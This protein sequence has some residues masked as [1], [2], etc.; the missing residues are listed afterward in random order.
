MDWIESHTTVSHHPKTRRLSRSLGVP[1]A[2]VVGHLHCLWHWAAKFAPDGDLTKFDA[3]D[4]AFGAM[5]DRGDYSEGSDVEAEEFL[6]ALIDRRF[7]D[8]DENGRRLH[9]WSTY[10]GTFL[11]G[12]REA[13]RRGAFG[14]HKRWHVDRKVSDPDC[15]FC[16]QLSGASPPDEPSDSQGES[17]GDSPSSHLTVPDL[18]RPDPT[19]Q[20]DLPDITNTGDGD[21][22][23][24]ILEE[25]MRGHFWNTFL[26]DDIDAAV[27][28]LTLRNRYGERIKDPVAWLTKVL[29]S[30]ARVHLADPGDSKRIELP[31]G[32]PMEYVVGSGWTEVKAS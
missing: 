5:W 8:E 20:P 2:A 13:S 23:S 16:R 7:I 28:R 10:A 31:D 30:M 11:E 3:D 1:V 24:E 26:P 17:G 27:A 25:E 19:N 9:N 22:E 18:T 6:K 29:E 15:E 32:T 12:K 21:A 4:I 14:N